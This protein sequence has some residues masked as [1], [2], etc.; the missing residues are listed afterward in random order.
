MTIS[1]VISSCAMS[2]ESRGEKCRSPQNICGVSQQN[3][4]RSIL[5]AA[6]T[7]GDLF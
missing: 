4:S 6:E 7:D 3:K 5:L 1:V 2:M